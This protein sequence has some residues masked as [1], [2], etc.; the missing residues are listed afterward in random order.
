[1]K[2]VWLTRSL[3]IQAWNQVYLLLTQ[4]AHLFDD[5]LTGQHNFQLRDIVMVGVNA[6]HSTH[7]LPDRKHNE[8]HD[9][10]M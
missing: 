10:K 3:I 4:S 9:A 7:I 1:M 5:V 2:C 8:K 6:L